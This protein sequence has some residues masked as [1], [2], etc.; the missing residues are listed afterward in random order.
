MDSSIHITSSPIHTHHHS[1]HSMQHPTS[2]INPSSTSSTDRTLLMTKMSQTFP[3]MTE[4]SL[5]VPPA[6]DPDS[7]HQSPPTLV[8]V[9]QIQLEYKDAHAAVFRDSL[10]EDN[11]ASNVNTDLST[12]CWHINSYNLSSDQQLLNPSLS[13]TNNIIDVQNKP[14]FDK[15]NTSYLP[16]TMDHL[17]MNTQITYKY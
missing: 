8:F 16:P 12:L 9:T 10:A 14:T 3:P 4:T 11:G 1:H 13:P 7:L 6:D 2:Y 5:T 17:N 15:R